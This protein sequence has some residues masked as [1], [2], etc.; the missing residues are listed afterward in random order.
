MSA[1]PS[2]MDM[3]AQS[4]LMVQNINSFVNLSTNSIPSSYRLS[5]PANTFNRTG[6]DRV[7]GT[8]AVGNDLS[9]LTPPTGTCNQYLHDANSCLRNV[10]QMTAQLPPLSLSWRRTCFRAREN[11]T[12]HRLSQSG[13][14]SM[15]FQHSIHSGRTSA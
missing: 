2:E 13:H 5:M 3:V 8:L 7:P 4:L 6:N 10:D 9:A 14:R 12:I 1:V 11:R 15:F